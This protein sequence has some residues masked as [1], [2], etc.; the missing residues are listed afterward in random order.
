MTECIQLF[1]RLCG[2]QLSCS[3]ATGEQHDLFCQLS[4]VIHVAVCELY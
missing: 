3:L 1:E 4:C 2:I